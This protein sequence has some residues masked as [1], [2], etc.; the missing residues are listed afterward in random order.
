M[1]K[2]LIIK[3]LIWLS[4]ILKSHHICYITFFSIFL[5]NSDVYGAIKI[6]D[7]E[8]KESE[9]SLKLFIKCSQ[10]PTYKIFTLESPERIVIDIKDATWVGKQKNEQKNIINQVRHGIQKGVDHRMV[11][12]LTQKTQ[13]ISSKISN[14]NLIIEIK[15]KQLKEPKS[16]HRNLE[17]K[18]IV[19]KP[20]PPTLIMK[21]EKNYHNKTTTKQ[22]IVIDPG[23][24]GDDPGTIGKHLKIQEKVITLRYARALKNSLELQNYHVILTRD[25]DSSL[26][27]KERVK[28]AKSA[29]AHIFI[30][31]HA[32]SHPDPSMSG[33]SVYTLSELASD[34]ES[35][36][37]AMQ[38]NQNVALE[39]AS[40]SSDNP[41]LNNVLIDLLHRKTRN[42][43][44][45]FAGHLINELQTEV[46]IVKNAH[47][48]AAF[49]VLK[50]S[51][52]PAVLIELGYL[53]NRQEEQ[54]LNSDSYKYKVING[55]IKAINKYF[56]R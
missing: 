20:Q 35:E 50:G 48:F 51:D 4:L 18:L 17:Q 25:R 49:K 30:S 28:K 38:E 46:N 1:T 44:A 13:I 56:K 53:S 54:M 24:G 19:N 16:N 2:V 15:K 6:V 9:S 14:N 41:E 32:D 42:L 40:F 31:L 47:R 8:I 36:I 23:H 45:E 29:G 5:L 55:I 33:A 3:P 34:K 10:K 26:T 21:P 7:Y 27:L 12:D 11:L 39:D 22:V 43:S 37:L 52:I